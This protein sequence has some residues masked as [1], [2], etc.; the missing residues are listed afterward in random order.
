MLRPAHGMA[1]SL[2]LAHADTAVLPQPSSQQSSRD[3]ILS[4]RI[5][6]SLVVQQE[7]PFYKD[8]VGVKGSPG[9]VV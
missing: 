3:L 5:T 7:C 2:P 4:G 9:V 1:P 8:T 6:L